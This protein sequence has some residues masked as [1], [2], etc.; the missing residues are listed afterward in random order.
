VEAEEEESEEKEAYEAHEIST[1]VPLRVS[2]IAGSDGLHLRRGAG[3]CPRR[4][5]LGSA[6]ARWGK[7]RLITDRTFDSAGPSVAWGGGEGFAN[8]SDPAKLAALIDQQVTQIEAEMKDGEAERQAGKALFKL[9]HLT[10]TTP[11]KLTDGQRK[12]IRDFIDAGGTLL[13]DAA[14]G[15]QSNALQNPLPPDSPLYNLPAQQIDSF[16]YRPFA[17]ATLVGVLNRPR[18]C[19][20]Q[21]GGRIAAYFSRED[22]SAGLVGEP[23]DGV[24]GYDPDTATAI[25]QNIVLSVAPPSTAA[26]R[27]LAAGKPATASNV[28]QTNPAYGAAM[29]FDGNPATRWA[30][31]AGTT[32]AWISVDLGKPRTVGKVT[33][34]EYGGLVRKFQIQYQKDGAWVTAVEGSAI[35]THFSRDFEPVKAQVWRLNINSTVGAPSIFEIGLFPPVVK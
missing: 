7:S 27:S 2:D 32:Q 6:L 20:I 16:S 31:D 15:T 28:Y 21:H 12:E 33:M 22:L 24:I 4:A 5:L 29:A 17:R 8:A 34:S 14:G 30:T 25:M 19:A 35:G 1:S 3:A 13:I 9:A 10:G 11:L 26:P 18:L 23:V